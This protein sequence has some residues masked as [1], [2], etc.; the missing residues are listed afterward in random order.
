[1][2]SPSPHDPTDLLLVEDNPGDVRLIQEALKNGAGHSNLHVVTDGPA[3]LDFLHQEG[4]HEQ[5]PRPDLV[6]LDLN[7]PR[8][9]G[10]KILETIKH[11]PDLRHIPVV[12]LTSSDASDDVIASYRRH[13]NAYLIKPVDPEAF[14]D[15]VQRIEGFWLATAQLA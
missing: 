9:S 5:A 11:D 4:D 3:A 8:L 13:A 14:I 7:L 10:E 15:V 6:L 2:P 12:V 1:M